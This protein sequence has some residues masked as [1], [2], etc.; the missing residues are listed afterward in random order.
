[1]FNLISSAVAQEAGA[2][3]QQPNALMSFVPFVLIFVVFYFLMIRP[4][5]KKMDEQNSF[6]N[7]LQKG[8][9]VYTASGI[10]GTVYGL[11]DKVVTLDVGEGTKIKVLKAQIVGL[12]QKLFETKEEKKK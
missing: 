8:A 4:Q 7:N 1:M 2:A 6:L 11:T 5:K 3:A 10:I 12:A 9:E